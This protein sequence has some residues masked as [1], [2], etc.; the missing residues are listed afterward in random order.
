[1]PKH[2]RYDVFISYSS[3]DKQVVE[4]VLESL[5]VAGLKPFYA[6]VDMRAGEYIGEG[7]TDGLL[8]SKG[9]VFFVSPAAAKSG[10]VK[11]EIQV[12]LDLYANKQIKFII[13]VELRKFEDDQLFKMMLG[14]KRLDFSGQEL[15]VKEVLDD[16][17]QQL[18]VAIHSHLPVVGQNVVDVPFVII[19]MNHREARGLLVDGSVPPVNPD[20]F[21][22]L[23]KELADRAFMPEHLTDFYGAGRDDWRSPLCQ[24]HEHWPAKKCGQ[25]EAPEAGKEG[26]RAG[27]EKMKAC[28]MVTIRE[29]I[30][31]VVQRINDVARD[32]G[33]D[34]IIDPQFKS[35]AF[36]SAHNDVRV[37]THRELEDRCV[38]VVDSLSLFHPDLS[39]F[40]D[41][42]PLAHRA[43]NVIPIA[44]PPPYCRPPESIDEL[45]ESAMKDMM[46]LPFDRF[47]NGDALCEFGISHPRALKRWLFAALP[48]AARKFSRPFPTGDNRDNFRRGNW[49]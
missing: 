25:P 32:T 27:G 38:L 9:A 37:K 31:N 13:F 10:W 34:L 14:R 44:V 24:A 29:F 20:T 26:L 40:L 5:R 23:M 46:T 6:E 3:S 39:R 36:T 30:E 21:A 16:L 35:E 33:N 47:E 2:K 49:S 8:S 28:E 7:V 17:S 19:A 1:M 11:H 41:R 45:I 18:I 15:A 22:K 12:A 42:S 48:E 43:K 4:P